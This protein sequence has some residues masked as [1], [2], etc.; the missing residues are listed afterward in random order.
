[1]EGLAPH[2]S[3]RSPEGVDT[4]GCEPGL[5]MTTGCFLEKGPLRGA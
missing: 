5:F 4:L 1:M 2:E 3:W